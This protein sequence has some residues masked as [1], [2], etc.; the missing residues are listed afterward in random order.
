MTDAEIVDEVY[1]Q[2]NYINSLN[3]ISYELTS[4]VI[5]LL[6]NLK[7]TKVVVCNVDTGDCV[8]GNLKYLKNKDVFSVQDCDDKNE[9]ITFERDDIER[10]YV[11]DMTDEINIRVCS[12]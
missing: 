12:K 3:T 11:D 7:R 5:E 9:S 1:K 6:K 2:A 8:E 4:D 10:V